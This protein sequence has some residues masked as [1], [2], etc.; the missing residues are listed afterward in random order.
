MC[1][2]DL[3]RNLQ[4]YHKI[5]GTELYSTSCLKYRDKVCSGKCYSPAA[6]DINSKLV[7]VDSHM[8]IE[9]KCKRE[10]LMLSGGLT[11]Q[12]ILAFIGIYFRP[13]SSQPILVT[14][15]IAFVTVFWKTDHL[16][17]TTEIHLLPVRD[18]HTHALSRNTKH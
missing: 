16:D 3:F 18:R 15:K 6:F 11:G 13:N 4:F 2:H 17:T 10:V 5:S 12:N 8:L 9:K 7:K 1:M 14:E